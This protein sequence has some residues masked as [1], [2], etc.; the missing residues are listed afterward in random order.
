LISEEAL[1]AAY[2]RHWKTVWH[3]CYPYFLNHADTEDAVQ[4]TFVRLASVQKPFRDAEHEKAWLIVTARNVCK[5]EL[6]R[7]SRKNIPLDD[8]EETEPSAVSEAAPEP[9]ETLTALSR[10]P[11]Q[12][13]TALYLFYYEEYSTAEIARLMKRPEVTV[14]SDLH[15]GRTLLKKQLGGEKQ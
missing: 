8:I 7:A 11:E 12:Y 6:R 9:D 3:I 2:L 4:D 10:L 14:R 13:R 15:R 1:T 5:N